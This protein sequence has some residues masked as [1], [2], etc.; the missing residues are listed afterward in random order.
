MLKEYIKSSMLFMTKKEFIM[1]LKI[2]SA[3]ALMSLPAT[4]ASTC[5]SIMLKNLKSTNNFNKEICKNILLGKDPDAQGAINP[6]N[7]KPFSDLSFIM[8]QLKNPA[9]DEQN[10]IAASCESK[11]SVG[12]YQKMNCF[13]HRYRHYAM[14]QKQM[15]PIK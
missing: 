15:D 11:N 6:N 12:L 5:T 14:I 7:S 2:L 3:T 9:T 1:N 13:D 4:K 8:Y 10:I